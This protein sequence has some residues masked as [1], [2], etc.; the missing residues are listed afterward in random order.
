M[1][2][3]SIQ[4]EE[5]RRR[6]L[7]LQGFDYAQSGAYFVTICADER[8]PLFG[9]ILDGTVRL[10]DAGL[11]VDACWRAIPEHASHVVLDAYVVMPDHL[12]GILMFEPPAPRDTG[13]RRGRTLGSV[14]GSFKSA[15]S[16]H[17]NERRRTAGATVWQRNDY[18]HVVRDEVSLA[19]IQQYIRDNPVQ[20]ALDRATGGSSANPS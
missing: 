16:K 17:L 5:P 2:N 13:G 4:G 12:H 14:I 18:E 8:A 7:R 1:T 19:R 3:R 20:W 6:A 10:S 11:I 15:V 9:E